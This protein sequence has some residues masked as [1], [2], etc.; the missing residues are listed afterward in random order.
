M[1]R[2]PQ[3]ESSNL[4][5]FN[6]VPPWNY[7]VRLRKWGN[8]SI[9]RR[10]SH[11]RQIPSEPAWPLINF[12]PCRADMGSYHFPTDN[13]LR[14]I[15]KLLLPIDILQSITID[16]LGI[17]FQFCCCHRQLPLPANSYPISTNS[18]VDRRNTNQPIPRSPLNQNPRKSAHLLH[19]SHHQRRN[20]LKRAIRPNLPPMQMPPRKL[21]LHLRQLKRTID[22]QIDRC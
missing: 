20:F 6:E 2:R 7:S 15:K 16:I 19:P 14:F 5:R 3:Q 22:I 21:S 12:C 17:P 1:R 13:I 18:S 8:A 4:M 10:T 9:E 11:E